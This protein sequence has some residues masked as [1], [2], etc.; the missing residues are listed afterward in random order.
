MDIRGRWALFSQQC[1]AVTLHPTETP[2]SEKDGPSGLESN[3]RFSVS[4]PSP[5]RL[6][7]I[8]VQ[9]NGFCGPLQ[10]ELGTPK[11]LNPRMGSTA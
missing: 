10:P 5:G 1:E 3:F 11:G 8:K 9:E 4:Q 2:I 6:P 7:I